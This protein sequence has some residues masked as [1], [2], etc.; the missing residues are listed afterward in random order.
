MSWLVVFLP[1]VVDPSTT[2]INSYRSRNSTIDVVY[3][4]TL[5]HLRVLSEV[6]TDKYTG[7]TRFSG[8]QGYTIYLVSMV[9]VST[10][11]L[12]FIIAHFKA[13]IKEYKKISNFR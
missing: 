3:K 11:Y 10:F 1:K 2:Q 13:I 9:L 6:T 8:I 7:E 4:K 5:H 12:Q